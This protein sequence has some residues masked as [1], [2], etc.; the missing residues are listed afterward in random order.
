MK[1]VWSFSY[2]E[3][4]LEYKAS[5][6]FE[7]LIF[8]EAVNFALYANNFLKMNNFKLLSINGFMLNIVLFPSFQC[9]LRTINNE[10]RLSAKC[11]TFAT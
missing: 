11:F 4:L 7:V 9:L 3:N 8:D 6:K 5:K 10:F 2:R 1:L